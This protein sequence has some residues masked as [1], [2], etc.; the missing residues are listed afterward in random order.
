M[1]KLT[2]TT[3]FAVAWFLTAASNLQAKDVKVKLEACPTA[4]Q[5]AIKD[6][7]AG[8]KIG[9]VEKATEDK[10]TVYEAEIKTKD[11]K[12][13][14][15]SVTPQGKLVATELKVKPA[16]CPAA[17]QRAIT[18]KSAGGTIKGVEKVVTAGGEVTYTAEIKPAKGDI[19]ELIVSAKGKVLKYEA[20]KD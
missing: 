14:E 6:K 20:D 2:I 5:K 9:K 7:A 8:G 11:G 1:K 4:V 16:K 15:V 18:D 12:E 17:V 10:A 3:F 19:M 13:T